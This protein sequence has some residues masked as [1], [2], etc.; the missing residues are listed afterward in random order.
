M[1]IEQR[2]KRL[3]RQNAKMKAA[4]AGMAVVLAVVLLVGSGQE[5]PKVLDEVSAKQFVVTDDMGKTRAVFNCGFASPNLYMYDKNGKVVIQLGIPEIS[6]VSYPCITLHGKDQTNRA[7][8][9]LCRNGLPVLEL[10]DNDNKT[11]AIFGFPSK[12]SP[13]ISLFDKSG[14][15]IFKAPE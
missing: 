6:G 14:K 2:F 13:E 10:R 1:T 15:V 5:K 8:L 7:S 12:S 9:G 3:E 11:R 4:V